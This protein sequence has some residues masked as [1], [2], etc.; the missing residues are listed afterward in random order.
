MKLCNLAFVLATSGAGE[1]DT[2]LGLLQQSF[3]TN[4]LPAALV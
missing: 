2:V 1:N 3:S 4:F